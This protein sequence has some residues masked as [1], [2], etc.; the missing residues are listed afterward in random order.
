M[1]AVES[2]FSGYRSVFQ[3]RQQ[4]ID[5]LRN[6]LDAVAE[7]ESFP[8]RLQQEAAAGE[9]RLQGLEHAKELSVLQHRANM[10]DAENAAIL[11]GVELSQNILSADIRKRNLAMVD[12]AMQLS[13]Q[14][15][16]DAAGQERLASLQQQKASLEAQGKAGADAWTAAGESY[17]TKRSEL[18]S[19]LDEFT[20]LGNEDAARV[21]QEAIDQLDQQRKSSLDRLHSMRSELDGYDAQIGEL[22]KTASAASPAV[23][24]LIELEQQL[25]ETDPEAAGIARMRLDQLAARSTG[26]PDQRDLK[27]INAHKNAQR[28]RQLDDQRAML[29]QSMQE[30]HDRA[31]AGM[32]K[33][34]QDNTRD[35]GSDAFQSWLQNVPK[36]TQFEAEQEAKRK[37]A[38]SSAKAPE[39]SE[40]F[41]NPNTGK[42]F[43]APLQG[44]MEAESSVA[45]LMDGY[46][47]FEGM[48][49][50]G[51]FGRIEGAAREQAFKLLGTDDANMGVTKLASLRASMA[52]AVARSLQ[53]QV[54]VLT[55]SDINNAE[56]LIP[57]ATDT[58]QI[59]AAK[60][61]FLLSGIN[62]SAENV[63][64][65]FIARGSDAQGVLN[66]FQAR[67]ILE[68]YQVDW[69]KRMLI[70][71]GEKPSETAAAS[72]AAGLDPSK[73]NN[74]AAALLGGVAPTAP[75]SGMAPANPNAVVR[76]AAAPAAPITPAAPVPAPAA[77]PR[78]I[79]PP[80]PARGM[81]P[82]ELIPQPGG[83]PGASTSAPSTVPTSTGP[84][85]QQGTVPPASPTAP[86]ETASVDV[87]KIVKGPNFAVTGFTRE[88]PFVGYTSKPGRRRVSLDYNDS[89]KAEPTKPL[90]VYPDDATAEEI[91]AANQAATLAQAFFK[92]HGHDV[93]DGITRSRHENKRGKVGVFHVELFNGHDKK[94]LKIVEEN[95]DEF[96]KILADSLGSL[97]DV[98]FHAPHGEAD[99][100]SDAAGE[101]EVS[102]ARRVIIP[103]LIALASKGKEA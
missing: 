55:D 1:S 8:L 34:L 75:A 62:S 86:Q 21:T 79:V 44:M 49:K 66:R 63:V 80:T 36:M 76:P 31:T 61:A 3:A 100:G 89:G 26:D 57:L 90:I 20:V 15:G 9:F 70:P 59:A 102:F 46:I 51:W 40:D 24:R 32:R 58:P 73:V 19:Q 74:A 4:E 39:G 95:P 42:P 83:N 50:E 23:K 72:G 84:N 35:I 91:Q 85:P 53:S 16:L 29:P 30:Q 67:G 103:R 101:S 94:A 28:L 37:S 82:T 48:K 38:T 71:P 92:K 17:N 64:N 52:P 56:K 93:G 43:A 97:P 78:Q 10:A 47:Q 65:Q 6:T 87:R 99:Q 60:K 69:S 22:T 68:G 13:P 54:G 45:N 7:I 18:L 96:A 41:I 33:A 5:N 88:N 12:E 14:P 77:G 98:L 81:R 27:A 25:R 2:F 11:K